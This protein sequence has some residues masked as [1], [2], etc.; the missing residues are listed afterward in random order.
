MGKSFFFIV[1]LAFV[2]VS[3]KN[4]ENTNYQPLKPNTELAIL[5]N[6]LNLNKI[7][8]EKGEIRLDT[9][10][11]AIL[12]AP[13]GLLFSDNSI[14]VVD[15]EI[16]KKYDLTGAYITD[17][18]SAGKGPGQY[19]TGFLAAASKDKI[20]VYNI[21]SFSV[22]I[23]NAK[24]G[25]AISQFKVSTAYNAITCDDNNQIY[26]LKN[27]RK[28]RYV[29][30]SGIDVYSVEGSLISEIV[31]IQPTDPKSLS[32]LAENNVGFTSKSGFLYLV[33]EDDISI[34]CYGLDQK[35][36]MWKSN[37]FP[38]SIKINKLPGNL[39]DENLKEWLG[40][41]PWIQNFCAFDNGLIC[42][43]T[44]NEILLYDNFGNYLTFGKFKDGPIKNC[45]FSTDGKYLY[46]FIYNFE[47]IL[48][49]KVSNFMIKTYDVKIK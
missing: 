29:V 31:P 7:F 40:S 16:I 4:I 21:S 32:Y 42:L 20:F 2:F 8:Q 39:N 43:S 10:K 35:E 15:Q 9:S 11:K 23:F 3:C 44:R 26:L 27:I 41:R 30:G 22:I 1:L 25:K 34:K 45:V 37:Y 48:K 28:G 12:I 47:K 49:N 19:G 36:N 14:F 18:G 46:E 24:N 17:I 33:Q 5:K 38:E 6:Q 13:K